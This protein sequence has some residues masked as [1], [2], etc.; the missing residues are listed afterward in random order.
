MFG[1]NDKPYQG[2]QETRRARYQP[3]TDGNIGRLDAVN[4]SKNQFL[5]S[6]RQRAA[7]TSAVVA[8]AGRVLFVGD[9]DR[10]FQAFDMDTGK[11][12]WKTRLNNA[13]SSYPIT[14]AVNGKQYV[15][16]VAG[17]C[18]SGRLNNLNQLT[19]EVR[20][21]PGNAASLWVF[22]LGPK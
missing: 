20:L 19:P 12:L 14:Y 10:W 3:N 21:P 13:V 8:T 2:A 16:V 11:Q 6:I 4:W 15:A 7:F 17:C 9:S 18:G 1:P 22:E 5:W